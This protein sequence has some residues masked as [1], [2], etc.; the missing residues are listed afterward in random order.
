MLPPVVQRLPAAYLFDPADRRAPAVDPWEQM[1]SDERARVL[2]MLPVEVPLAERL[3][4]EFAGKLADERRLR[5]DAQRL[6]ADEQRQREDEQRR[7]EEAEKH[8]AEMRAEIER[9]R[10]G[11]AS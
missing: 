10:K 5:E 1:S 9:L 6:R 8:V 4:E 7:R 2:A 3:A 11:G